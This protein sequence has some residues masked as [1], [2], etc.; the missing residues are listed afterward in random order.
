MEPDYKD[1]TAFKCRQLSIFICTFLGYASYEVIPSDHS[2][3]MNPLPTP[4]DSMRAANPSRTQ[5]T[6]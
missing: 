3:S 5:R 6:R 2:L 4:S 1:T